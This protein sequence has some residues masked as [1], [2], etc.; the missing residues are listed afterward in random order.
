MRI[1]SSMEES[2]AAREIDKKMSKNDSFPN[3]K[4]YLDEEITDLK[5]DD[6][7]SNLKGAA[8]NLAH[9]DRY[10]YGLKSNESNLNDMHRLL[11]GRNVKNLC[12][13]VL[14]DIEK[15]NFQ[16]NENVNKNIYKVD[17]IFE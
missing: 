10:F 13:T 9:A 15:W 5:E 6:N 11:K 14:K 3:K 7:P 4:I 16:V 17:F 8:L 12:E 2:T 1:L